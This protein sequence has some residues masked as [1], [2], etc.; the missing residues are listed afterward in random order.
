[1]PRAPARIGSPHAGNV[2]TAP[3]PVR[4]VYLSYS[5]GPVC[6]VGDAS[7]WR[8]LVMASFFALSPPMGPRMDGRRRLCS[9]SVRRLAF[10]PNSMM[11][12]ADLG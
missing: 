8:L 1:M 12:D 6:V 4:S 3:S 7:C 10:R 5:L 9:T 11:R 2:A